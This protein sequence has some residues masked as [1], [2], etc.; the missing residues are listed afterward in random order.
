MYTR[1]LIQFLV[2]IIFRM[3]VEFLVHS[4]IVATMIVDIMLICEVI[5]LWIIGVF[6]LRNRFVYSSA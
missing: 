2:F 1:I 4:G 5:S 3:F 6:E